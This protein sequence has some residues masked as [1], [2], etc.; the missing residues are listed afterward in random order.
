MARE[1]PLG[2]CV[3]SAIGGALIALEGAVLVALASPP[4]VPASSAIANAVGATGGIDIFEGVAVILLSFGLLFV[5]SSHKG[6][7][8]GILTFALLSLLTGGGFYLGALFGYF[9]G[10]L[11]ILFVPSLRIAP[12]TASATAEEF[13]DPVIEADLVDAGQ[14]PRAEP[15]VA[16]PAPAETK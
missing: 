13:D 14:L 8:I 3:L 11:G 9:G 16:G 6:I 12:A 4:I 5:P 1:V 7:G 15:S 10:V 2:A